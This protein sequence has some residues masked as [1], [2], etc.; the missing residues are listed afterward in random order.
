M[1]RFDAKDLLHLSHLYGDKTQA[2]VKKAIK[3]KVEYLRSLCPKSK[4]NTQAKDTLN[5]KIKD[6]RKI[7]KTQ[8]AKKKRTRLEPEYC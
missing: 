7:K 3:L 1:K 8:D 4:A 5:L 6:M 2:E